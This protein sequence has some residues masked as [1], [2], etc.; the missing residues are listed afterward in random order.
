MV[1]FRSEPLMKNNVLLRSHVCVNDVEAVLLQI[2]SG[3]SPNARVEKCP[4][5]L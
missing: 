1:I 5:T 2:A 4:A 3:F